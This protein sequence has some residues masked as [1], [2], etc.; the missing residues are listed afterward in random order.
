MKDQHR[1]SPAVIEPNNIDRSISHTTTVSSSDSSQSGNATDSP[2]QSSHRLSFPSGARLF[3]SR[4]KSR[5]TIGA[6]LPVNRT[7]RSTSDS[8]GG[9]IPRSIPTST[10][11]IPRRST[12]PTAMSPIEPT[13]PSSPG[14]QK[15]HS[16]SYSSQSRKSGDDYRRY[17]GTVNHY[18]RHSN[19][20]LFG[21]FSLRDTVREG[22]DRLRHGKES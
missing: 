14:L 19:D 21:G 9:T 10:D 2:H 18:G 17:S 22:V 13:N 20:W 15:R 4:S 6:E 3:R 7:R 5:A 16:G 8:Y 11:N 12:S 1:V